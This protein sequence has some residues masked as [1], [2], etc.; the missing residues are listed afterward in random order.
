MSSIMNMMMT[1]W[2]LQYFL[3]IYY[4]I[5]TDINNEIDKSILVIITKIMSNISLPSSFNFHY[6]QALLEKINTHV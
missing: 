6:C 4:I 5:C 3:V 1:I 2:I